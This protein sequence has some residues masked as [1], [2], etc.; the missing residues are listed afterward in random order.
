MLTMTF[1][2]GRTAVTRTAIAERREPPLVATTQV[3]T[4]SLM[5]ACLFLSRIHWA[6]SLSAV[7]AHAANQP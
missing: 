5:R 4:I 6:A 2:A 7:L 1:D 3:T